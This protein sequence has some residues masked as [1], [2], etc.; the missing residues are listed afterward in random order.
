M[1]AE[2]CYH[3]GDEANARLYVNK[4]R[5]RA[6]G[7]NN[8]VLPDVTA[9]GEALLEAIYHERRVELC[10]ENHRFFDL[11]RWGRL[12]K[13]V[14]TD[15]YLVGTIITE[16]NGEYVIES[17]GNAPFKATQLNINTHWLMPIPQSEIDFTGGAITQNP[18]Y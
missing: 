8:A 13:E 11:I 9:S 5:E 6:R 4:V 3:T 16:V 14:K 15:G 12:E 2:A 10:L 18:G 7:G 17:D 1:Y